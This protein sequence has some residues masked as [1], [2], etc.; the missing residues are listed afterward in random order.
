[1]FR[2]TARCVYVVARD[3]VENLKN[4][5]NKNSEHLG[6]LRGSNLKDLWYRC[7]MF[8][9]IAKPFVAAKHVTTDAGTGLVH[10]SYAHGFHDYEVSIF[11]SKSFNFL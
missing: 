7:C 6:K 2:E 3:Q 9:D 10:T 1:M 8:P 4:V 5:T 11:F